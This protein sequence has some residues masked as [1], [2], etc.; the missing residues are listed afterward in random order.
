MNPNVI[1]MDKAEAA[2]KADAY[3][4]ALAR[5]GNDEYELALTVYEALESGA[6]VIDVGAAIRDGGFDEKM[7]PKLALSRADREQAYFTWRSHSDIATFDTNAQ[8]GRTHE[9][10]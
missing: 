4:N 10:L 2:K 8:A 5:K 9:S 1:T 6:T 3:R 7:R